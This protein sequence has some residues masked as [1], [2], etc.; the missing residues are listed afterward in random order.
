MSASSTAHKGPSSAEPFESFAF[1]VLVRASQSAVRGACTSIIQFLIA[2]RSPQ[3]LPY[4]RKDPGVSFLVYPFSIMSRAEIRC[5]PSFDRRNSNGARLAA[6]LICCVSV[7]VMRAR[8][9]AARVPFWL[10]LFHTSDEM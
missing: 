5:R 8:V 3:H 7:E 1:V 2:R 9:R 6:S 10:C 4:V